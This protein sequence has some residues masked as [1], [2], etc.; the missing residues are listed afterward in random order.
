MKREIKNEGE[1]VECDADQII[2]RI[3]ELQKAQIVVITKSRIE[4]SG[5][6]KEKFL[7][8]FVMEKTASEL[9]DDFNKLDTK[10][11]S[12]TIIRNMIIN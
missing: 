9:V 1:Y 12:D 7:R 11:K 6:D 3:D 8:A 2:D 10:Q 5:N 4:L